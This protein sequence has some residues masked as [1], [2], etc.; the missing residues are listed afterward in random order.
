MLKTIYFL[1]LI[2]VATIVLRQE[3]DVP[4]EFEGEIA[5]GPQ[6]IVSYVDDLCFV[7]QLEE[8]GKGTKWMADHA[9]PPLAA[10]DAIRKAMEKRKI[11]IPDTDGHVWSLDALILQAWDVE[12]G[13][14]YWLVQFRRDLKR[15]GGT[16]IPV[17]IQLVVLMDGTVV[18][19]EIEPR[20]D[21]NL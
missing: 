11:L 1:M 12:N 4:I 2:V 17:S 20:S 13:Y 14:W 21:R 10:A 3:S 16:G 7:V 6:G 18:E 19:P 5:L 15:G 9:N 8:D